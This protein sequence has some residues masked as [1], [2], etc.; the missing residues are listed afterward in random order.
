MKL[1]K[2]TK[3][4]KSKRNC[5]Q[6]GCYHTCLYLKKETGRLLFELTS[7]TGEYCYHCYIFLVFGSLCGFMTFEFIRFLHNWITGFDM[8]TGARWL[9]F[10]N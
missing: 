1:T 4:V 2:K 3:H 9:G 6:G 7:E 10:F 8:I 5:C